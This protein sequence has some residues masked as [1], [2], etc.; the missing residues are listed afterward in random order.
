MDHN[1]FFNAIKNG[2]LRGTYLLEG[3]EEYVKDAA[4]RKLTESVDEAA[5]S[6]NVEMLADADAESLIAA[7]ETLPF[8]AVQRLVVCKA[9]PVEESWKR[10]SAY[11][12]HLP[13]TTLLIFFVRGAA[14][15]NLGLVK[16]LKKEDRIVNCVPLSPADAAVWVQNQAKRFPVRINPRDARFLVELCGTDLTMLSNEFSKAACYAGAGNEVTREVISTAVTRNI[17]YGVFDMVDAFAAGKTE[18]GLRAL[19]TLL[20]RE[21]A[22]GIAALLSSRFKQILSARL[23]LEQKL[24]KQE[25]VRQLGGSPYAAGKAYDAAKRF[26]K[27]KLISAIR[28]FS[29]VSYLQVSGQGR[30]RDA[31]EHALLRLEMPG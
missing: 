17:E 12:P 3:E 4:I 8:L 14:P 11:L 9:L 29:D 28:D 26:S 16:A 20:E 7:C 22:F 18:N 10:I 31:L 25:A 15:G 19:H 27:E 23:L 30:D 6:L 2:T 24:S 13:E 1:S 21:S 5:R